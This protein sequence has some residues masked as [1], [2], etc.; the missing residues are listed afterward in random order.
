MFSE[1]PMTT[2]MESK[3]IIPAL[4]PVYG[5]LDTLAET[6]L[7]VVAGGVLV[8]HGSQKIIDPMGSAGLVEMIGFYPGPFW[9]VLLSVSEFASGILLVLGLLT[10]PAAVVATVILLVTVWF[11]WITVDQG[12]AGAEKSIL[13]AAMTIYFAIRGGNAHSLDARLPREI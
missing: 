5:R 8:V 2:V 9:S 4:G 3:L 11:H 12:F 7:R 6:V 1:I 10:R 13:W